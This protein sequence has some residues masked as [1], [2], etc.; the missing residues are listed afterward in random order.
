MS[1]AENLSDLTLSHEG[2]AFDHSTGDSYVLNQTG[3]V[4][5]DGLRDGVDET[6]LARHLSECFEV[7]EEVAFRDVQDFVSR[8]KLL[9]LV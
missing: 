3:L 2:F 5:L 1:V 7:T 4:V 6:Q 8:L 9:H